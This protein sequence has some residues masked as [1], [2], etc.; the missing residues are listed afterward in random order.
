ML[1]SNYL[2][3]HNLKSFKNI[4]QG[5]W[6]ELT[7]EL[8][9]CQVK[10]VYYEE[11]EK[12]ILVGDNLPPE[13]PFIVTEK[14]YRELQKWY[15]SRCKDTCIVPYGDDVVFYP[16]IKKIA[17]QHKELYDFDICG[18]DTEEETK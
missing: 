5:D 8:G 16:N 17:D 3:R 2:F 11:G 13:T 6:I 18:L 7:R 1:G 12:T 9:I 15:I 4:N 10:C 14:R